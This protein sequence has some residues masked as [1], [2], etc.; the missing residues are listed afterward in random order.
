MIQERKQLDR[1]WLWLGAALLTIAVF[2][3]VRSLT[4]DR[5]PVRVAAAAH[6]PL[7]NTIST[8][9]RVEPE[10]NYQVH[11]PLSTTVNAVYVQPGDEVAAGKLLLVLDDVQA[12]AKEATAE[13]GVKAAQAAL[14]AVTH[15]GSQQERQMAVADETRARLERDEARRS[16]DALVKLNATGAASNNEVAAAR[17]RL[18]SAEA[19]LSALD[20]TSK[21]RY[22]PA[23][24]ER[25]RAALA[26]AEANLVAA[27]Q[28]VAQTSVRAP[29]AGTVYSLDAG[30]TEFV[31]EGK[32]LLQLADLHHERIRAYFDEPEIGRLAVGQ[33]IQIK[34]DAKPGRIWNGHIEQ[35]PVTVINLGTRSVGEVLV[36][37]DDADAGLLP[38]T[39]VTVTVTISSDPDVLSIPREALHTE[40]GKTYVYKVVGSGLQRTY[41]TIGTINLTQV[42]ILSGLENGDVVATGTPSGL[43]LQEGIPIKVVR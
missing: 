43:P 23:E 13:S 16:L 12:R 32:L 31:E 20:Q 15:N 33:K 34:W 3:S 10:V 21:S 24:I 9:G 29:A 28:V 11:S 18:D 38:D 1:R 39:N 22:S 25:A 14:E 17:Q 4:R 8:N 26:D 37:I 35:T 27:R 6:V 40:N 41:V 5:L 30:R 2:F 36:K 19:S 42:A 7:I